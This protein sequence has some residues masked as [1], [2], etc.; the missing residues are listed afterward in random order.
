MKLK[1]KLAREHAGV[2][3][4][5]PDTLLTSNVMGDR[6]RQRMDDYLAGFEKAREL[7]FYL[8]EENSFDK[9]SDLAAKTY[10]FGDEQV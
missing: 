3:K 2:D 9:G 6:L 8:C 7:L 1:E 10:R 5:V 4:F